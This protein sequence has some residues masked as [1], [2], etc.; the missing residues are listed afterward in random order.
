MFMTQAAVGDSTGVLFPSVRYRFHMA[1]QS[2]K[3]LHRLCPPYLYLAV[4]YTSEVTERTIRKNQ[5]RVF[6]QQV[7]TNFG[8]NSF[9]FRSTS[10]WN[11]LTPDICSSLSLLHFKKS[12]K[13]LFGS[14]N[15]LFMLTYYYH[16]YLFFFSV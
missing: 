11:S 2:C 6:V 1:I 16:F 13:I 3:I 8:K 5:F 7:R 4:Q 10:I 15:K 14:I 12:L 9:A